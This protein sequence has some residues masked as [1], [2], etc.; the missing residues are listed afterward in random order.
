MHVELATG[1]VSWGVL[2]KDTPNV[3]PYAQVLDEMQ[4]A[5]YMGTELGP[6][7]YLPLQPGLLRRELAQRDLHL[8][9]AFVPIN[10]I[11][12]AARREE[13]EEGL[14]VACFLAEMGCEWIV[15]SDAL[16]ANER[17]ARRAGC[18]RP[19]DGLDDAGWDSFTRNVQEFAR[20]MRDE[21]G[22]KTVHHPHVGAYVET[23]QEVDTLLSRTDPE[24][25]GLC[26]DTGHA[27]YGGDDPVTLYQRWAERVRYLHLKDVIRWCWQ[28]S[29][30]RA[31]TILTVC[32]QASFPNWARARLIS[33]RSV[34]R[35]RPRGLKGGPWS[36]RIFCPARAPIP[37]PARATTT[38]TC[39]ASDSSIATAAGNTV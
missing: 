24:L 21:L 25:I 16:F 20:R 1:P 37:W 15:L 14:T 30:P 34:P 11:N 39:A 23:P 13:Y 19:E 33:P 7:G 27:V 32:R 22:L 2:L 17:R 29:G 5:G 38:S 31:E 28:R 6:Y 3:P 26:L 18:I 35:W 12:P 4:A 8:L 36:N 10:L 9:S